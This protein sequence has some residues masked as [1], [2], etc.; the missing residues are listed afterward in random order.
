[1]AA[2]VAVNILELPKHT[3]LLEAVIVTLGEGLTTIVFEAVA[4]QL[5]TAATTEYTVVIVG[6]AFRV[7][8]VAPVFQV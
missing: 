5:P 8:V 4:L 1:V 2:P 6:V 7:G 3:E